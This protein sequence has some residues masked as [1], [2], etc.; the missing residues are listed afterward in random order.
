MNVNQQGLGPVEG[1]SPLQWGEP[2]F[3]LKLKEIH[4]LCSIMPSTGLLSVKNIY[5]KKK[6]KEM[7]V[8]L[9]TKI[10]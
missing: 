10:T 6:E 5:E 7:N 2:R 3:E 1:I 8:K 9:T 4:T